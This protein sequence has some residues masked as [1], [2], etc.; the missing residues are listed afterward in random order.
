MRLLIIELRRNIYSLLQI[1]SPCFIEWYNRDNKRNEWKNKSII[2]NTLMGCFGG[3][4][5]DSMPIY[6]LFVL[7]SP[8]LN[9]IILGRVEPR[10]WILCF[11]SLHL[12]QSIPVQLGL[13]HIFKKSESCWSWPI[14]S[15][16]WWFGRFFLRLLFM[17]LSPLIRLGFNFGVLCLNS[18]LNYF[19][20]TL[21]L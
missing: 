18:I 16:I 7:P 13:L 19:K 17:F 21:G 6:L 2:V 11:E 12:P 20:N 14:S 10:P 15:S 1:L 5:F 8:L 4:Y 9:D 3:Q